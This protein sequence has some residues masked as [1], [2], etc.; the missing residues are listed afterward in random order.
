MEQD[1]EVSGQGNS[2]AFKYRIHD[3]RLG[4]FLS[5]DPLYKSYPW[6]STYAFAENRVIDGIDLEG[7]EFDSYL[8]SFKIRQG[9]TYI[10]IANELKA[11]HDIDITWQQLH[12]LNG[13][14]PHELQIG[15]H[16]QVFK[17]V[18]DAIAAG[19][20]IGNTEMP[21]SE[22]SYWERFE[23]LVV[24]MV[25]G[26]YSIQN[27]AE[28]LL[29]VEGAESI[30]VLRSLLKKGVNLAKHARRIKLPK[31]DG[32][33]GYTALYN[34]KTGQAYIRRSWHTNEPPEGYLKRNGG[35]EEFLDDLISQGLGEESDFVGFTV[36]KTGDRKLEI[37]TWKSNSVNKEIHGEIEYS[38]KFSKQIKKAL[39]KKY[40]IELI[41]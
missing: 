6:N 7:R 30:L 3:A 12:D 9:D 26:E 17:T 35:H 14:A 10:K 22:L 11:K 23:K 4:R 24:E 15:D 2:Y 37:L 16:L 31:H 20:S 28:V 39:N 40:D 25:S 1:D 34:T 19:F 32:T 33:G 29:L 8:L 41:E 18:G 5:V 38:K 21:W 13:V 36:K 27:Q